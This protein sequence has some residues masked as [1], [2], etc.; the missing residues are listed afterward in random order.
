MRMLWTSTPISSQPTPLDLFALETANFKSNRLEAELIVGTNE[1][2]R[3]RLGLSPS[4]FKGSVPSWSS[5]STG[6]NG[7]TTWS[8]L[9]Q[10][11]SACS[12]A[13]FAI[14]SVLQLTSCA[15]GG[16]LK[17]HLA[18]AQHWNF[19]RAYPKRRTY[20]IAWITL[21][22]SPTGTSTLISCQSWAASDDCFGN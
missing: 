15:F 6:A 1:H 14:T 7:Q 8:V 16:Y 2:S 17:K 4:L 12:R 18:T 19:P 13:P 5:Q 3:S 11:R 22:P 21:S 20:L 10:S 9:Q